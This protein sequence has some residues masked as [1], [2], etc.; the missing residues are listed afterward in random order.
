MHIFIPQGI[1]A[2]SL[3]ISSTV[4]HKAPLKQQHT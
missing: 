3:R 2:Y 4:S 1:E